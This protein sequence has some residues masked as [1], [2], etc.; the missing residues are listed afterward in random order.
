MDCTS[1]HFPTF[2]LENPVP[3]FSRFLLLRSFNGDGRKTGELQSCLLCNACSTL[4]LPLARELLSIMNS[5][6]GN[7][8]LNRNCV[9]R[10]IVEIGS[11][12]FL[13]PRQHPESLSRRNVMTVHSRISS[14]S[15]LIASKYW[16]SQWTDFNRQLSSRSGTTMNI[17]DRTMKRKQKK[18]AA[19][20]QDADKYDYLRNEVGGKC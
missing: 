20:L 8:F 16:C 17:F 3:L 2:S 6:I 14:L 1:K 5:R 19:S 9:C 4:Y 15:N 10:R 12:R 18:W 13:V 7:C 11:I